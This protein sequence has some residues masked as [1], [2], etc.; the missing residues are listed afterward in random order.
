MRLGLLTSGGDSPGMNGVIRTLVVAGRVGGHEIIGIRRGYRGLL[1]GDAVPLEPRDVHGISR[2]GGTILGSSRSAEFP[3]PAGQ[4]RARERLRALKLDALVVAGGNGSLAGAHDLA[5][6]GD[7]RV[8][9]LPASIDNDV[10]HCGLA[11]GTD[12]AVNTIVEACDRISDTAR[13]HHRAF[14]VEVM[15]RHCG[16]LA[17]RAGIA[18]EA[19]AILY[20]EV[21]LSEDEIVAK[22]RQCFRTIF[23][24]GRDKKRGLVI[25][26][27]GV[28][29]P[30]DAL[31]RRLQAHLDVDAPGVEIRGTVLGHVVRGG[32]PSALDRT[33][34]Q[35]LAYAALMAAEAGRNDVMLSWD[36]PG[37]VGEPTPDP[38]VRVVPLAAVLEE[39]PRLVD[40]TSPVAA[41]RIALLKRVEELFL[42]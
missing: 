34:G 28:K 6:A 9:G 26:S 36:V 27:E 4:A 19:D 11:I 35:R 39:S 30:T 22:L 33:I 1:E 32:S 20:G 13:A 7:V 37:G 42:Y 16:F 41:G 15:G 38:Y 10:G 40:G 24:P 25:K 23:A 5:R 21:A 8:L 3:T 2:L 29:V 14:I 12:T 17:M 31:V 18:V